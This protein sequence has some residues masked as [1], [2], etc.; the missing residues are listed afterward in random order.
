MVNNYFS[1][2]RLTFQH[3][4]VNINQLYCGL[5]EIISIVSG[6]INKMDVIKNDI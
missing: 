3:Q 6:C 5:M 4:A 1:I 2:V